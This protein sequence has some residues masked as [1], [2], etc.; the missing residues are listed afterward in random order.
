MPLRLTLRTPAAVPLE[1]EGITPDTVRGK[2]LA[3]IERLEVYEGNVKASMADFFAVSGD[4]ADEVHHWEG[5]LKGVHWVGAK[6]QSGRIVIE[7]SAGRHIGS[8]MR[9]GE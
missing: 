9:G 3:E 5:D 6:M 1:V 7:G 4:A 2:S 8:E